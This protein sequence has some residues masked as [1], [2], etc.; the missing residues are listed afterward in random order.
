MPAILLVDFLKSVRIETPY[1]TPLPKRPIV[2][3]FPPGEAPQVKAPPRLSSRQQKSLKR[4][5]LHRASQ[6]EPQPKKRPRS[7]SLPS[8]PGSSPA[9]L[10]QRLRQDFHIQEESPGSSPRQ[11]IL[12]EEYPPRSPPSLSLNTSSLDQRDALPSS[13]LPLSLDSPSPPTLNLTPKPNQTAS[14]PKR[15]ALSTLDP[16]LSPLPGV[17]PDRKKQEKESED[18]DSSETGE[19][20]EEQSS[21]VEEEKSKDSKEEPRSQDLALQVEKEATEKLVVEK[22]ESRP[23]AVVKAS[24]E[25]VEDDFSRDLW[26]SRQEAITAAVLKTCKAYERPSGQA[27]LIQKGDIITRAWRSLA[28]PDWLIGTID[29][30]NLCVHVVNVEPLPPKESD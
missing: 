11:E 14:S 5:V 23:T 17:V 4:A 20:E 26:L 13:P 25:P 30:R 16:T 28:E 15:D 19:T 10:S 2:P 24:E 7:S 21:D 22:E 29:G 8:S 18:T 1:P 9:T 27:I 6:Q 12:R 3:L